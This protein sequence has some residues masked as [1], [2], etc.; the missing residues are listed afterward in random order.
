MARRLVADDRWSF[1]G[2]RPLCLSVVVLGALSVLAPR[3]Q[4]AG[5]LTD[6]GSLQPGCGSTAVAINNRRQVAG[7][8]CNEPFRW[9]AADGMRGL[10]FLSSVNPY[11][12]AEAM[13]ATGE[14]TG[15]GYEQ[16]GRGF[17]SVF[18]WTPAKGMMDL[19]SADPY[20]GAFGQAVNAA[21]QVAYTQLDVDG[22][23]R[24]GIWSPGRGARA[25]DEPAGT[26][27]TIGIGPPPFEQ[28]SCCISAAALNN[29]GDATGLA[30]TF[31]QNLYK[32]AYLWTPSG[33]MQDLGTLPDDVNSS[34]VA[35]N[36]HQNIVGNSE[37]AD[38]VLH[39]F[40]W[41]P[42]AAMQELTLP[43][44]TSSTAVDINN[45]G[46]V[47][48]YAQ[49]TGGTTEAFLWNPGHGLKDLGPGKAAAINQN[50]AVAIAGTDGNAYRWTAS[51]GLSEIGPGTPTAINDHGQ[52]TGNSTNGDA[53]LW[54]PPSSSRDD[55]AAR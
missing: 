25:L 55:S 35:I 43:G 22:T 32:H 40:L 6:L 46:E 24:A 12:V 29:R 47:V 17:P 41:T 4:A 33:G 27:V 26:V 23:S 15:W 36:D 11:G 21:G 48:G 28:F 2:V 16:P 45:K 7:T 51:S 44:A 52:I 5:T 13:N 38:G 53:F 54:S 8:S 19:H 1:R 34:G 20:P 14:V 39:A 37:D 50:G 49:L 9:T 42:N 10:G 31:P 3:A 18:L 30:E